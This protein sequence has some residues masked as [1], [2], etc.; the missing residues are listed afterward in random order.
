VVRWSSAVH[1]GRLSPTGWIP[2]LDRAAPVQVARRELLAYRV[3]V[4]VMVVAGQRVG[5]AADGV[6]ELQQGFRGDYSAPDGRR[7]TAVDLVRRVIM[8]ASALAGRSPYISR[9]QLSEPDS[10]SRSVLR[11]KSVAAA[12]LHS[13]TA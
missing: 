8:T 13:M 5:P 7:A 3:G 2:R 6:P 1:S 12:F 11:M 10:W 4:A 9:N